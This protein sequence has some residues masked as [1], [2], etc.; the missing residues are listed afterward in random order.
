MVGEGLRVLNP[1]EALLESNRKKQKERKR[2]RFIFWRNR[3][4][5]SAV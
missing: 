1:Y 2:N 4:D 5:V 3:K